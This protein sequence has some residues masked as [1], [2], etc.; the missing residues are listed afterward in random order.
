TRLRAVET[1]LRGVMMRFRGVEGQLRGV[2]IRLRG[3]ESRLRGV[4]ARF[5]P[6]N[7]GLRRGMR[8]LRIGK[9]RVLALAGFLGMTVHAAAPYTS[10]T[11]TRLQNKVQY[12]AAALKSRRPAQSGDVDKADTYLLT[13]T[14]SR[15]E[16]KYVDGTIVRI[17]QNTVFTL[18]ADTR[19]LTLAHA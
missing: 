4:L 12:G 2:L 3:V 18:E 8:E 6:G 17:G 19:A 7:G 15:A 5:R 9:A 14:D 16:L 11:V 10:A 13:E 1:Q